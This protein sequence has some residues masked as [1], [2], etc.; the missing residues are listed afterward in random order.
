V[1][2]ELKHEGVAGTQPLQ[3]VSDAE[4]NVKPAG[5]ASVKVSKPPHEFIWAQFPLGGLLIVMVKVSGWPTVTG[6]GLAVSSKQVG[7][8][9]AVLHVPPPGVLLVW[10][11]TRDTS[12]GTQ[13]TMATSITNLKVQ[14]KGLSISA[15]LDTPVVLSA[16]TASRR[17]SYISVKIL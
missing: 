10:P 3:L 8:S 5:K 14:L 2:P 17:T 6:S 16:S 13:A 1:F 11:W 4:T 15:I 7:V 9:M 12:I